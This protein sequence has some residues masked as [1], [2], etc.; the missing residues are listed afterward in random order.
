MN[1][2]TESITRRYLRLNILLHD[3]EQEYI[4]FAPTSYDV[5]KIAKVIFNLLN[6]ASVWFFGAISPARPISP[7][8]NAKKLR[9]KPKTVEN[10]YL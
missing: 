4:G 1:H 9:R 2:V 6:Y 3:T 10:R 5:L 7:L 8:S